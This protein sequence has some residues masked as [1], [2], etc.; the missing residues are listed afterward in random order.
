[1]HRALLT[2]PVSA[3]VLTGCGDGEPTFAGSGTS[4]P[5]SSTLE[6]T[7]PPQPPAEPLAFGPADL[8]TPKSGDPETLSATLET[9]CGDHAP[10]CGQTRA[11]SSKVTLG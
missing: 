6:C 2:L 8:P 4:A 10:T 5:A 3:L 11:R 1:M 7:D 9:T